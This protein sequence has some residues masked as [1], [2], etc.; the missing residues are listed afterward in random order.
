MII[1][2]ANQSKDS[3]NMNYLLFSKSALQLAIE[4]ITLCTVNS[5]MILI[6]Q[7]AR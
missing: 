3:D 5:F 7:V 2:K 1:I 6:T 4:G